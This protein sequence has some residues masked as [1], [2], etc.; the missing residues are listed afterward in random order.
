MLITGLVRTNDVLRKHPDVRTSLDRW[1]DIV[2][3]AEWQNII[4][5]RRV[6]PTADLIKGTGL[7]CFNL[8]GNKYRLMTIVS[9]VTQ[10]IAVVELLTHSEYDRKYA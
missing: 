9:Y 6:F 8:G 3:P 10:E 5:A 2:E 7:T 1:I 4:D